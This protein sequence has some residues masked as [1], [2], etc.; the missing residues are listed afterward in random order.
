MYYIVK[1]LVWAAFKIA[2][3]LRFE[4]RENIPKGIPVIY[5]SN[6]RTNADP[7]LVGI[8]ARGK[9]AFIRCPVERE[10]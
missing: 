2:Y 4:G 10:T 9:Y 8:G 6:H 7:P 5:A 1:F 3:S